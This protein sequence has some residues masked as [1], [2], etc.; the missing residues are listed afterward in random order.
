LFVRIRPVERSKAL[1]AGLLRKLENWYVGIIN[2]VL[3]RR[4]SVI[5]VAVLLL[6]G[7]GVDVLLHRHGVMPM[8]DRG[9]INLSVSTKEGLNLEP[10]TPSCARLSKSY[11]SRMM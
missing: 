5:L 6:G 2:G 9:S 8:M 7:N 11:P 1:G 10:P 4:L 3:R